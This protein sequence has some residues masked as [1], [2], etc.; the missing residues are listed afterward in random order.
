[1]TC[2]HESNQE[3]MSFQIGNTKDQNVIKI[4]YN[5]IRTVDVKS[6]IKSESF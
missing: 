6:H 5:F 3:K 1:M 2:Y 4:F